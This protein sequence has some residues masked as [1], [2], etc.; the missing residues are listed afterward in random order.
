M[1]YLWE[2][3]IESAPSSIN[4]HLYVSLKWGRYQLST[5]NAIY[6]FEDKYDNFFN[7]FIQLDLDKLPGSRVLILGLGLASI[8]FMLEKKFEKSFEYTAVELDSAVIFLASKYALD[9]LLSPMHVVE[10]DARRFIEIDYHE[11]DL[12]IMDVFV[13]DIIPEEME[14]LAF[15]KSIKARLHPDGLFMYNRLAHHEKDKEAS[16]KYFEDIFKQAFQDAC[17]DP[18]K[19]NYILLNRSDYYK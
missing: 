10:T 5:A 12:I 11:Y 18:V 4:P 3:H 14:Q 6:S 2:I 9:E 15:L 7:S 16:K 17:Y 8:P 19:G 1:S 13:D